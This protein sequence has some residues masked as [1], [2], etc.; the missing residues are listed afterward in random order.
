[1][2]IFWLSLFLTFFMDINTTTEEAFIRNPE[3]PTLAFKGNP[4]EYLAIFYTNL[5]LNI[6]TLGF[7]YPWSKIKSYKFFFN[8]TQLNGTGFQFH[9]TGNE[10]FKGFLIFAGFI[11]FL[12]GLYFG[13]IFLATYFQIYWLIA[14]AVL[15]Y[16]LAFVFVFPFALHRRMKY[17]TGRT[18][19]RGVQ[20]GFGGNANSLYI[21]FF[22]DLIL[23]VLTLGIYIFW[24]RANN[25]KYR[26][27]NLKLGN[28]SFKF[29]GE[30]GDLFFLFLI[31]LFNLASVFVVILLP[32]LVLIS[33]LKLEPPFQL[34]S[35]L[36]YVI[37]LIFSPLLSL[38]YMLEFYFNNT[39]VYQE[40]KVVSMYVKFPVL[41]LIKK[42]SKTFLLT[43][44]TCGIYA[45]VF[46]VD[47]YKFFLEGVN[48]KGELYLDEVMQTQQEYKENAGE[49]ISDFLDI[50]FI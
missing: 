9:G 47:L 25:I 40:D 2:I 36:Y 20:W 33:S 31:V 23:C 14:V 50:D 21:R 44:V 30:G 48:I 49:T 45:P 13:S 15:I 38:K 34:Y 43:L 5:F 26:I 17:L 11:L 8:N 6:V 35:G 27:E 29:K 37:F 12:L 41:T 7:Y 10:L 3:K 19:W 1:M 24:F 16:L 32:I 18:T 42:L 22:I 39:K 28:I 46:A 4:K